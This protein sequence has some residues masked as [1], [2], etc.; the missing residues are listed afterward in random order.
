MIKITFNFNLISTNEITVGANRKFFTL[1]L[2]DLK[3][4][5]ANQGKNFYYNSAT[6]S[7]IEAQQKT[8]VNLTIL[9]M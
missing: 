3:A 5:A 7:W 4:L 9:L 2:N 8:D 1:T 6:T